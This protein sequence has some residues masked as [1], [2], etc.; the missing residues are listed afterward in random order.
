M[1]NTKQAAKRVRQGDAARTHNKT[2]RSA[3]KSAIKSVQEAE[4]SEDALAK[5][6]AAMKKIDKAA[7]RRVLHPNAADRTKSRLARAAAKK[8]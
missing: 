4:T 2:I 3:M 1:P 8:S 5:L 6:P 7:K